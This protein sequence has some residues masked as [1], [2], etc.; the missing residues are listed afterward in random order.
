VVVALLV[1]DDMG[2][3]IQES[4]MCITK[5]R[6]RYRFAGLMPSRPYAICVPSD[7]SFG[8]DQEKHWKRRSAAE[9]PVEDEEHALLQLHTVDVTPA[10]PHFLHELIDPQEGTEHR[11]DIVLSPPPEEEP[12]T[13]AATE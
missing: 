6:G 5:A 11:L 9:A 4:R 7:G 1:R 8:T 12:A 3:W 13:A 2:R 10:N